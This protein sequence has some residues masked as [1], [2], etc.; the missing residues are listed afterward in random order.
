[1]DLTKSN[2]DSIAS[3]YDL[4]AALVFRNSVQRAPEDCIPVVS[5]ASRILVVGGGTGI[6]LPALLQRFPKAQICYLEPSGAMIRKAMSRVQGKHK[7]NFIQAYIEQHP[8][9]SQ[10][11]DLVVTPFVL[12]IFDE[13]ALNPIMDAIYKSLSWDGYWIQADFYL[14]PSSPRWQPLLLRMMQV[15]FRLVADLKI[16]P[17]PDFNRCF[18]RY[19]LKEVYRT[20]YFADMIQ[21]VCY[22][23]STDRT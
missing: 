1:M 17:L 12:D 13:S 7:I 16:H 2:F 18:K 5:C 21:A 10:Y 20:Y 8:L 23:N 4:L 14:S 22:Q 9:A 3:S 15:F 6:L 19:P 11:F